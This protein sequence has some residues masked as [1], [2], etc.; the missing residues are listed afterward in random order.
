MAVHSVQSFPFSATVGLLTR[1]IPLA[2]S[3]AVLIWVYWPAREGGLIL[4]DFGSLTVMETLET[5]PERFWDLV[6]EDDAGPLGRPVATFLFAAEYAVFDGLTSRLKTHSILL[7]AVNFFV[8]WLLLSLLLRAR[9]RDVD[10]Y[11]PA[12]I[13][14]L[15]WAITPQQT[16]TVLYL[17]QRM[18]ML[19]ALFAMLTLIAF[20]QARCFARSTVSRCGWTLLSLMF[21]VLSVLSKENGVVVLPI[22]M[23]IEGLW[24]APGNGGWRRAPA[25]QRL[26]LSGILVAA[27][28]VPVFLWLNMDFI[29]RGYTVR[30]FS[31]EDRVLS[32]PRA[33]ADYGMQFFLPDVSR[34]GVYHDDFPLGVASDRLRDCLLAALVLLSLIVSLFLAVA[35]RFTAL[36]FVTLAFLGSHSIESS[37]LALEPYFEHRNYF[38][39][40]FLALL[41]AWVLYQVL[42][43]APQTRRPLVAGLCLPM[44]ALAMTTSG[45]A[46]VWSNEL[47]LSIHHLNGHPESA[48]ATADMATRYA[49]LGDYESAR[50][51]SEQANLGSSKHKAARPERDSDYRLRNTAL[52]CLARTDVPEHEVEMLGRVNP[53]RPLG[54]TRGMEVVLEL[55]RADH[56]PNFDWDK[57]ADR[58]SLLYL[59]GDNTAEASPVMFR[60]LST[61]NYELI[62]L[63][64]ALA[65]ADRALAQESDNAWVLLTRLQILIEQERWEEAKTTKTRLLSLQKRGELNRGQT[66]TLALYEAL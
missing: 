20:L 61:F 33:I 11:W 63:D 49:L 34:M 15:L 36:A 31:L 64:D 5:E 29:E 13:A 54:D 48:R 47:L 12:L 14:A 16:S 37:V 43:F 19:S 1:W 60:A 38:P 35:G 9:Y 57:L 7:H 10:P 27:T 22:M 4:D 41:V 32:Q 8:L 26:V 65:Y 30:A 62:R 42:Q 2:L 25:R 45:Q 56:C 50:Q 46:M 59:H 28:L 52:A 18:A 53:E 23:L 21:L 17:V 6:R 44:I 3:V 24:I 40:V 39:S 66:E 58:L 55:V 51:L